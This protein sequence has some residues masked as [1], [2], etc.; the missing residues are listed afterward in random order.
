MILPS[1]REAVWLR[2]EGLQDFVSVIL[3]DSAGRVLVAR[4]YNHPPGRVVHEFPGGTVDEGETPGEAARR[5]TVEEVGLTPHSLQ[6]L[7]TFLPNPR[8]TAI[9]CHVFLA[10]EP[11][12]GEASPEPEEFI[13]VSWLEPEALDAMI[14]GGEVENG[15]MIAAWALYRLKRH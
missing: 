15:N 7:G 5:E 2:F 4:Q 9:R 14:R 11:V 3:L 1:G 10:R 12:A 6:P 8:R 13:E